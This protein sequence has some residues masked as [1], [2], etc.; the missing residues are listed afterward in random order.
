MLRPL[1]IKVFN[2]CIQTNSLLSLIDFDLGI[3]LCNLMYSS[4]CIIILGL[5]RSLWLWKCLATVV[6]FLCL[7]SNMW[8]CN[9]SMILFLVWPTY[10]IWHQLHC[11]QYMRLLLWHVSS[12][13][14][15]G[16]NI[17]QVCYFPWL[18][19]PC[20][21][22]TSIRPCT[23]LRRST[24][25]L[26]YLCPNQHVLQWGRLSVCNHDVL[27]TQFSGG[28]RPTQLRP[29]LRYKFPKVGISTVICCNKLKVVHWNPDCL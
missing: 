9:L 27:P 10:F 1:G 7:M 24:L 22:L 17:V 11:K 25:G 26:W 19:N 16:C 21:V 15:V 5:V 28:T 6:L 3:S 14:I 4:I 13:C 18:G 2:L 29:M 20:T 23:P 12:D 8:P